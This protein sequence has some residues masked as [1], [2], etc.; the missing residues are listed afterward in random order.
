MCK[1][2][3]VLFASRPCL[4]THRRRFHNFYQ[5]VDNFRTDYFLWVTP[6]GLEAAQSRQGIQGDEEFET[7]MNRQLG[8]EEVERNQETQ[9]G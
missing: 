9:E 5:Q 8:D 7:A 6:G 3:V 1:L 4:N 2:R